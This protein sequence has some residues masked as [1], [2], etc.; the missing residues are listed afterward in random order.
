MKKELEQDNYEKQEIDN[1][2]NNIL[3]SFK[4]NRSKQLKEFMG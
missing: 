1:I 2:C 3:N 4:E